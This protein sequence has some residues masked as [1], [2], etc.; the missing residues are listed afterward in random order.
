[1][2]IRRGETVVRFYG[3]KG[4]GRR[5]GKLEGKG[6][7]S[8]PGRLGKRKGW[9][10]VELMGF[11]GVGLKGVVIRRKPGGEGGLRDCN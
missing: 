3:G 4:G 1:M 7:G 6:G 2:V 9:S 8:T 11:P 5:K 10:E